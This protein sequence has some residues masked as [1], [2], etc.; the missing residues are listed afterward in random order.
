MN[1]SKFKQHLPKRIEFE[2]IKKNIFGNNPLIHSTMTV[3]REVLIKVPYNRNFIRSQDYEF[4]L[5]CIAKGYSFSGL[6]KKVVNYTFPL[7]T[8]QFS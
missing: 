7:L 1:G 5:R 4:W 2:N 3:R 6:E 8:S